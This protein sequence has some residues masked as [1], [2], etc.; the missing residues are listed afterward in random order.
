[1]THHSLLGIFVGYGVINRLYIPYY[2]RAFES[3]VPGAGYALELSTYQL[4]RDL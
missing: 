4:V 1:M 2:E 3:L